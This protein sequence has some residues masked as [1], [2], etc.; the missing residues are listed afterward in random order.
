MLE[1]RPPRVVTV[2]GIPPLLKL[3][4]SLYRIVGH[5]SAP[6]CLGWRASVICDCSRSGQ[7]RPSIPKR[8]DDSY[9]MCTLREASSGTET[10][11]LSQ[12]IE[13]IGTA[14]LA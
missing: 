10:R 11:K 8:A 5:A 14:S 13:I 6:S 4:G 9:P 7:E 1:A 12:A 2:L 3:P